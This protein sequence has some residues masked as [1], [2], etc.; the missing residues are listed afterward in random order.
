MAQ[1]RRFDDG[2]S[3]QEARR[4]TC[5]C[6]TH[7]RSGR[8]GDECM[9]VLSGARRTGVGRTGVGRVGEARVGVGVE[10]MDA[11]RRSVTSHCGPFSCGA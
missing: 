8:V 11:H 1:H 6:G 7:G 9:D 5:G 4:E 10:R 2:G 3:A